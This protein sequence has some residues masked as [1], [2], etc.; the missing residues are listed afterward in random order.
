MAPPELEELRRQLKELLDVGYIRSSKAPFGDPMLFQKNH[1]NS[2]RMCINYRVLNK[3][4]VNNK[5]PI[6]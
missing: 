5:Y 4:M 1:D 3:V 6:P 2:R